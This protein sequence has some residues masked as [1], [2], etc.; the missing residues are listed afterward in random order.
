MSINTEGIIAGTYYTKQNMARG[1]VRAASGTIKT[2]EGP[3]ASGGGTLAMSINTAGTIAG[4][5]IV[6][7]L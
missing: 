1:F 5:V 4:I 6:D 7:L 2:F 3:G